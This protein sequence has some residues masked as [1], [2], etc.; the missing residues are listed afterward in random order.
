MISTSLIILGIVVLGQIC[1]KFIIPKFGITGLHV[2]LFFVAFI[3]VLVQA[4][5]KM[6][7][8]FGQVLLKS[9]EY[10]AGA[11]ALYEI[12]VKK[13]SDNLNLR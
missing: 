6:N 12:I 1:K 9:G 3:I 10:L 13:I 5:S 8:T 4:Y 7:P 2:F 11:I